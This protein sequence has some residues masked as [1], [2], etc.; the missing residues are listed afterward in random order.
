MINQIFSMISGLF[1]K[2]I[3]LERRIPGGAG[4][5]KQKPPPSSWKGLEILGLIPSIRLRQNILELAPEM[6]GKVNRAIAYQSEGGLASAELRFDT[7]QLATGSFI[8]PLHSLYAPSPSWVRR[9]E[10]GHFHIWP[11]FYQT[12]LHG[13]A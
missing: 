2:S 10:E 6:N 5:Q 3:F 12:S 4:N 7:P 8:E 1:Q 13:P 9:F 11:L